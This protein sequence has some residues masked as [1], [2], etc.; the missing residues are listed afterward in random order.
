M[1]YNGTEVFYKCSDASSDTPAVV[2]LH[3]WGCTGSCMDGAYR[4]LDACGRRVCALDFPGFGKSDFPP[5]HWGIYEYADCVQYVLGELQLHRPVLVGHSFGG[6]VALI[7]GARG[8]ASKLV[9]TDAAG[10]K[11]KFSLRK[12]WRI[13]RYKAAKRKG[14]TP[15]YAGSADYAALSPAMQKVFVRVVNTHLNA[16]LPQIKVPTLLFWGKRDRDTPLYMA[17]KLNKGIEGSGLITVDA[18]HFAYA[19][20][21]SVFHAAVR[22]FTQK[23]S[24]PV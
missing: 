11:P 14:K 12:W 13:K 21:A 22:V 19:E 9:L 4:Y 7:L 18:G 1:D 3:G 8:V 6:R 5:A 23:E 17:R 20:C 2:L 15:K 10:L 16:L 24:D